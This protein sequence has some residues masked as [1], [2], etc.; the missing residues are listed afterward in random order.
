[1]PSFDVV[2]KVNL[3]EISNAVDQANRE[4]GTRFDFK[5]TG[6]I[7]EL[8]KDQI[9]LTA[10]NEFQLKQMHD[11]LSSKLVKRQV[12]VQSLDYQPPN[13]ALHQAKQCAKIKQGIDQDTAK[14]IVKRI[15]EKK[16]KVQAS[17]Q[18]DQVRVTG[19]K[20]DD[21]QEVMGF[22]KSEEFEL[23]LQYDNFRD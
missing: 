13:I 14:I 19:K 9:V 17:I 21:L 8:V 5:D 20:K 2:S 4:V 6:A 1:M 23:P 16:L 7:F 11:I 22:L 12:D 18:G 3:N 10:Q 15:K